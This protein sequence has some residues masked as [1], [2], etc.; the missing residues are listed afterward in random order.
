MPENN[1]DYLQAG[2]DN[3]K[4]VANGRGINIFEKTADKTDNGNGSNKPQEPTTFVYPLD[5]MRNKTDHLLIRIFDQVRSTDILKDYT[6]VSRDPKTEKITDVTFKGLPQFNDQFNNSE[7]EKKLKNNIRYI[8]LPI[9]QQVSDALSVGYAEDSLNPLQAGGIAATSNLIE[10]PRKA[11]ADATEFS[12]AIISGTFNKGVDSGTVNAIKAAASGTALNSFGANV[13]ASSLI[14]R[15]SGQIL[16]SNLELL[17]SNVTLRSFPF[18][19]D[20][21]PRNPPE[22]EAVKGIIRTLKKAMV[23]KRGDNPALFIKAPDVFQ[24]EYKTGNKNHPFLNMFKVCVLSDLAV[25]YTASG[26]YATYGD[27]APVHIQ[28]QMTFKEIN[29]I[30]AEDYDELSRNGFKNVGY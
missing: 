22:A 13:S 10:Q 11:L 21:A 4:D 8:F 6:T 20:F 30:Y 24:L 5:M 2:I 17:F 19:Y 9:P 27:A 26:T 1:I 14:A 16:Q 25:N 18:V 29:P 3:W 28:V 23:P 15:A 12:K 7:Y